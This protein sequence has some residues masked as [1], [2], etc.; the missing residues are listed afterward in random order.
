MFSDWYGNRIRVNTPVEKGIVANDFE[1]TKARGTDNHPYIDTILS[2]T[3]C[4]PFSI[5]FGSVFVNY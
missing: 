5:W 1:I 3:V 4:F 2:N